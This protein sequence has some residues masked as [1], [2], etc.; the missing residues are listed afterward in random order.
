MPILR[1]RGAQDALS[2]SPAGMRTWSATH[3]L[4]YRTAFPRIQRPG[5]LL[6]PSGSDPGRAQSR[7]VWACRVRLCTGSMPR[8]HVVP[9]V[10]SACAEAA[11]VAEPK[12]AYK[13]EVALHQ[14]AQGL[15]TRNM[16]NAPPKNQTVLAFK[17]RRKQ[18]TLGHGAAA[19]HFPARVLAA[20]PVSRSSGRGLCGP[21]LSGDAARAIPLTREKRYSQNLDSCRLGV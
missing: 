19:K 12:T 15:Q 5:F 16:W 4:L 17:A 7:C 14:Q 9:S 8:L 10:P 18:Q 6:E 11:S 21:P 2:D 20:R 13:G 3:Y 1:D